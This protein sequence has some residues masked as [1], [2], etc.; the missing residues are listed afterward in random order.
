MAAKKEPWQKLRV[1]DRVRIVRLPIYADI[2]GRSFHRETRLLYENLIARRRAV[3]VYKID[4]SGLPWVF[5]KFKLKNGTW[6]H[7]YLAINDDSWMPVR[8]RT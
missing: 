3:R 8:P 1:G 2:P 5:C 4:K 6:D 7:H